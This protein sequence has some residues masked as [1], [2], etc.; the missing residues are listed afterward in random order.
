MLLL[1]ALMLPW[2]T[3][4]QDTVTIGDTANTANYYY[5]P[6]NTYFNYSLT[7][8]LFT[9]EEIGGAGTINS[10]SFYY[11]YTAA[12]S[13]SG[14]QMYMKNVTKTVFAS[15][16]DMEPISA[17]DLVWTGTLMADSAGWITINL[18]TPFQYDGNSN[19]LV[20]CYDPTSGYPGSSYKFRTSS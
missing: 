16:T 6:I 19:L 11:D 14:V 8:Q 20:C 5:L 10:I 3:R 15:N 13:A 1:A 12:F 2:A 9:P 17:N 18:D 4:V 7:Q